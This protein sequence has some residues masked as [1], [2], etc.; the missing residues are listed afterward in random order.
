MTTS[1]CASPSAPPMRATSP[2]DVLAEELGAVAG[3]I[4]RESSLRIQAAVA[5]LERRDAERELRL[6]RLEQTINERLAA[7]RDGRDGEPGPI[8]P[9]G[10][11][12]LPGERG[13]AGPAGRDGRDGEQG[14]PGEP[15]ERGERG[16]Q[17]ER[18]EAGPEGAKGADGLPGEPGPQGERGER[19]PEGPPGKLPV[20]KAWSDR[21]HYEGEVTAHGGATY[22]AIR[23]TGQEPGRSDDWICLAAPGR[24]AIEPEHRGLYEADGEYRRLNIVALDGGAFIALRDDPGP[25][26]GDGWRQLVARGKPG[27]PGD[28]GEKG[29][30]GFKGEQ[31]PV[32]PALVGWRLDRCDYIAVPVMSDGSEAA[33]LQLRDLFEQ[34]MMET[35]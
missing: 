8:G 15:G 25:L 32:A 31:G 21:V 34:F 19:G 6:T 27:K 4:E 10:E 9:Q 5:D 1:A 11:R 14:P 24:D 30:R 28:K 29:E 22:Q 13:E 2:F 20:V 16:F 23:D 17:G 33:P 7:V 26:P 3:R 12:G 35:R 18:G